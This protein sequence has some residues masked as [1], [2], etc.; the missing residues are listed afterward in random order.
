MGLNNS[1]YHSLLAYLTSKSIRFVVIIFIVIIFLRLKIDCFLI[2]QMSQASYQNTKLNLEPNIPRDLMQTLADCLNVGSVSLN[3][4]I[5]R[6][7][8]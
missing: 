5:L 3:S 2:Q 1:K 7:T 4:Y 6:S 8:R